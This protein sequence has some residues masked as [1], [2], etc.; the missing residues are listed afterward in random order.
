LATVAEVRIK[1][2]GGAAAAKQLNQ[3][4]K[5]TEV[6]TRNQTRLG[7]AS[8]S[9]GRQFSAQANGLGGLVGAYAGAA[10]N[11][12][13]ITAAFFALRRAA[14]FEQ[15][16]SG[17]N[18]LAATIGANGT[19]LVQS[20]QEITKSQLSLLDTVQQVNLA[21]VSGF[22][23]SQIEELS[24]VS[25]RASKALGRNLGDAFTRIVRGA[26][27]L[28][29]ELLDELGIFTRIDPA[30]R[31]YADSIGVSVSSLTNFER[32]QAFVNAVI[33][34][35][36]TKYRDVDTTTKTAAESLQA[37]A[38]AV[39][40]T[41]LK[42]G[43]ALSNF[44]APFADF[45]SEDANNTIA[46]FGVLARVVGSTAIS[47][48]T[49]G[50]EKATTS[51]QVFATSTAA[52]INSLSRGFTAASKASA[53]FAQST[54]T[55]TR[56]GTAAEQ[57]IKAKARATLD[58]IKNN[59]L[60]TKAEIELAKA[61][62]QEAAAVET[63]F[64]ARSK[65]LP[66]RIAA[67]NA[68]RSLTQQIQLLTV[69][70]SQATVAA[71][72]LSTGLRGLAAAATF[73]GV[74]ISRVL[75]FVTTLITVAS[76]LQLFGDAIAQ[77]FGFKDLVSIFTP[78][79]SFFK[80]FIANLNLGKEAI[81]GFASVANKDLRAAAATFGAL[82]ETADDAIREATDALQGYTRYLSGTGVFDKGLGKFFEFEKLKD[83]AS[84][85]G[86]VLR[87]LLAE[88][89]KFGTSTDAGIRGLLG[90]E[91]LSQLSGVAVQ[92]FIE[93]VQTTNDFNG[94][95]GLAVTEAGT[96]VVKIGEFE[97]TL[98]RIGDK[99]QVEFIEGFEKAGS[100]LAAFAQSATQFSTDFSS[101]L[102]TAERAA[103]AVSAQTGIIAQLQSEINDQRAV[104]NDAAVAQL[105][106]AKLQA[107]IQRNVNQAYAQQITALEKIA[108]Q[109][110]KIYGKTGEKLSILGEAG[111][112]KETIN[113]VEFVLTKREQL[114]QQAARL[115]NRIKEANQLELGG[116]AIQTDLINKRKK[117]IDAIAS[118][119]RLQQLSLGDAEKERELALELQLAKNALASTEEKINAQ[120]SEL[121]PKLAQRQRDEEAI[122]LIKQQLLTV[123]EKEVNAIERQQRQ[124]VIKLIELNNT[125]ADVQEKRQL[126][127]LKAQLKIVERINK[128]NQTLLK[129][130][131]ISTE[132]AELAA[133]VQEGQLTIGIAKSE[134]DA[135]IARAQRQEKLELAKLEND[136]KTFAASFAIQKTQIDA[137]VALIRSLNLNTESSNKLLAQAGGQPVPQGEQGRLVVD[138]L[139]TLPG[140]L[141][142]L[143]TDIKT[144][145][146]Q[147]F[148]LRKQQIA[149]ELKLRME[150]ANQSFSITKLNE[151]LE[152]AEKRFNANS[153]VKLFKAVNESFRNDLAKGV[154]DFFQSI[155]DGTLTLKSFKEGFLQFLYDTFENIRKAVL[156][157]TLIKPL[158]EKATNFLSGAFGLDSIREQSIESAIESVAGGNALRVISVGEQAMVNASVAQ[159]EEESKSFVDNLSNGFSMVKEK[160]FDF[161]S[162]V[163]EQ[164]GALGNSA[165]ELF[166]GVLQGVG[167]AGSG[168]LNSITSSFASSGGGGG[169]F[170]SSLF[171]SFGA[172]ASG[173]FVPSSAVQRLAAGGMARDRIPTLL[174]P[175]EFVMKRSSANSIGAPALNQMNATGK[176]G[177]NVVVNIQNQ[178]TPQDATASEPRFDGEKF[179]IDIVTRDLRNNGPIRKSL[180]GGG[181]G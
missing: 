71:G 169:G 86:A 176:A 126:S 42:F 133:A 167:Q 128:F 151:T 81:E 149:E 59:R 124:A 77:F 19:A 172:S 92:K 41:G 165:K 89:E 10:A 74:A 146:T 40:D 152:L 179:V 109:F 155:A 46:L 106:N 110:D 68:A 83:E 163:G 56:F 123:I 164:F 103:A 111:Q 136:K 87:S 95:L 54:A 55:L 130:A 100:I 65:S 102:L 30:V 25:L 120:N 32:R 36:T 63:A 147:S 2:S 94:A 97:A 27:K 134:R 7:Q 17:T 150:A 140:E 45:I 98:T 154:D 78:I 18:A 116:S 47:A 93:L 105:E 13:A 73:A 178:G 70:E 29:P 173:G 52:S 143:G 1:A 85:A 60:N 122:L 145:T 121:I 80:E 9:A 180:R 6:L 137:T 148:E 125:L 101:G 153:T 112:I 119:Q 49:A 174:E 131:G 107:Q 34:E 21:L 61:T 22:N 16:I 132:Q 177:G 44:I 4:G 162:G 117:Q 115:T 118:I 114:A 181:A 90:I 157:E 170:F 108:K 104:G 156:Q 171:S 79:I 72:I 144:L 75:G 8:A 50:V 62:L 138:F 37:L 26:A 23:T 175:G 15:I 160:S 99:G 84:A 142:K 159:I 66:N 33:E 76:L 38:A 166:G 161:F 51:I 3:V 24:D 96:L 168:I 91:Q 82:G 28:E 5:S 113:G 64:R 43:A 58:D 67:R 158:Q 135:S 14:E 127:A 88:I 48:L 35:G 11:V 53:E 129:S 31:K 12:F 20:V 139:T 141:E 39:V 57:A 69:A